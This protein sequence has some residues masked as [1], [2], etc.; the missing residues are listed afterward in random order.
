M[1]AAAT[2]CTEEWY[3]TVSPGDGQVSGIEISSNVVTICGGNTAP[4]W[5]QDI[6]MIHIAEDSDNNMIEMA[7]FVN[8]SEQAVS[9]LSL[10]VTGNTSEDLISASFDGSKLVMSA[11]SQNFYGSAIATLTLRADDGNDFSES[12][13]DVSIDP[14][15]DNPVILSYNGPASFDEDENF[16]FEKYN[17]TID[18]PDNDIVDMELSVLPGEKLSLIHI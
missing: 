10:S 3:A 11:V 5:S 15:N 7:G 18:D 1:P 9:Q 17:F 12:F 14:V 4:V 6:P 8:D 13:V 2:A 16:V